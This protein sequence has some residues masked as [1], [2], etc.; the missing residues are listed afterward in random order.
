[1]CTRVHVHTG[2]CYNLKQKYGKLGT[3]RKETEKHQRIS[4]NDVRGKR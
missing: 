1:V 4:T 3:E 2:V